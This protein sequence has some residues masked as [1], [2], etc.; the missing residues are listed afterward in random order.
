MPEP[1]CPLAL[2]VFQ[3]HKGRHIQTAGANVILILFQFEVYNVRFDFCKIALPHDRFKLSTLVRLEGPLTLL[4][5][6]VICISL[7][8]DARAVAGGES[9]LS[10][11]Y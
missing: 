4:L 7:K 3:S 2:Y 9:H 10:R 11:T 1:F 8:C 5:A 6:T